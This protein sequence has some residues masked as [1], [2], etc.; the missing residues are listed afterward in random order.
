MCF[1]FT[2]GCRAFTTPHSIFVRL[3]IKIASMTVTIT[4]Y[5]PTYCRY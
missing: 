3:F 1:N 4:F 2:I 5:F